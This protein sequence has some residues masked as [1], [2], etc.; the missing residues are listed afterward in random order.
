VGARRRYIVFHTMAARRLPVLQNQSPEEL[1]AE[2]RPLWQWVLIG[3]GYVVCIWLPLVTLV[4]WAMQRSSTVTAIAPLLVAGSFVLASAAAG[5]LLQRFGGRSGPR[6]ATLAGL[7]AAG[8]CAALAL[9]GGLRPW[10]F[11][12]VGALVLG[13]L[14]AL[15]ARGGAF[16]ARRSVDRSRRRS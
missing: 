13:G 14:G 4:G 16:V 9:L 5:A 15:A 7:A 3:A 11:A 2:R 10:W 6:E 1:A 8:L 12:I